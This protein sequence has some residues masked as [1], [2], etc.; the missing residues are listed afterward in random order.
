[1]QQSTPCIPGVALHLSKAGVFLADMSYCTLNSVWG[2]NL[3][4]FKVI[5]HCRCAER[6][7]CVWRW[8]LQWHPSSLPGRRGQVIT[9]RAAADS[10]AVL[11]TGNI[12]WRSALSV[13]RL[14]RWRWRRLYEASFPCMSF[15]ARP[16]VSIS[17]PPSASISTGCPWWW[18]CAWWWSRRAASPGGRVVTC[19]AAGFAAPW[20]R[21]WR[22]PCRSTGWCRSS[23]WP[24]ASR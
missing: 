17:V 22:K 7:D 3:F 2:E 4:A 1:M 6:L 14:W 21:C 24:A 19:S 13:L 18:R 8:H 5:L 20:T 9:D 16:C 23:G 11:V 12:W 10:T 15:Q